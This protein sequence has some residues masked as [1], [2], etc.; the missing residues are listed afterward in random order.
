MTRLAFRQLFTHPAH[1][2]AEIVLLERT[3]NAIAVESRAIDH[4]RFQ[5]TSRPAP[6]VLV[7]R[8]LHHGEQGLGLPQLAVR[9]QTPVLGET[10]G[11]PTVRP[12]DRPL[13]IVA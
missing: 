10:A 2:R 3:T 5:I 7:L 4:Q 11:G 13:L 1:N 9:G 8:S 6:Q 12:R